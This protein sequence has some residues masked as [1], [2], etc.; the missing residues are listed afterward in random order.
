MNFD[1]LTQREKTSR[2]KRTVGIIGKAFDLS[3][4]SEVDVLLIVRYKD[5]TGHISTFDSTDGEVWNV[6]Q[7]V[8]CHFPA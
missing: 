6:Q 4:I 8:R 5:K 7:L 3:Q 2:R 1:T